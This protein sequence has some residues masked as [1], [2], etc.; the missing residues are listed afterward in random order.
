MMLQ[1]NIASIAHA[2]RRCTE[3]WTFLL[4]LFATI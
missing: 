2:V 3:I 1:L 4:L